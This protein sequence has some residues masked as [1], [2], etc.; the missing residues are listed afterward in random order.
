M[1]PR[2]SDE[3]VAQ[4]S[5]SYR[6]AESEEGAG[7]LG[8]IVSNLPDGRKETAPESY[9]ARPRV[10]DA[11]GGRYRRPPERVG[12]VTEQSVRGDDFEVVEGPRVRPRHR[13]GRARGARH[14]GRRFLTVNKIGEGPVVKES[15]R[16]P[17]RDTAVLPRARAAPAVAA[18]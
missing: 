5:S 16:M 11:G 3:D 4:D 18:E 9:G 8:K 12:G 14:A 2:A 15:R 7:L 10:E 1:V 17:E 13:R 6:A